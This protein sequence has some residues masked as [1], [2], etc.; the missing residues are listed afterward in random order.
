MNNTKVVTRG[1]GPTRS[2]CGSVALALINFAKWIVGSTPRDQLILSAASRSALSRRQEPDHV[3]S[4][5]QQPVSIYV[6]PSHQGSSSFCE[7]QGR[8]LLSCE[9]NLALH[10][11]NAH[12]KADHVLPPN[13]ATLTLQRQGSETG[14]WWRSQR[15]SGLRPSCRYY[16]LA[17]SGA[18]PFLSV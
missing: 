16:A 8:R 7:K 1:P 3:R 18:F 4:K 15:K 11:T 10:S 17:C 9:R 12:H 13:S 2:D 6:R 14:P 5:R